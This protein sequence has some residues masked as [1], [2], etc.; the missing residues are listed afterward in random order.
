MPEWFSASVLA[1]VLADAECLGPRHIPGRV[2]RPRAAVTLWALW[3]VPDAFLR[4]ILIGLAHTLYRV[5][6][7]G[8]PNVPATGGR[9]RCPTTCPSP[10]VYS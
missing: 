6:M 5:R 3:L 4:F 2:D 1:L 8:L 7:I 10:T 9:C